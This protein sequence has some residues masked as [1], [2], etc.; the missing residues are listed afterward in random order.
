[1]HPYIPLDCTTLQWVNWILGNLELTLDNL[2]IYFCLS[3]LWKIELYRGLSLVDCWLVRLEYVYSSNIPIL[4]HDMWNSKSNH[5]ALMTNTSKLSWDKSIYVRD[6]NKSEILQICRRYTILALFLL[7]W[8]HVHISHV[9]YVTYFIAL[10]CWHL[11]H[12]NK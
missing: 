3:I 10:M 11:E 6:V 12:K 8:V 2:T 5:M 4:Y 1:M 9:R 7:Y